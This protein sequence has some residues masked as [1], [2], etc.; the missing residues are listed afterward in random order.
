MAP[1]KQT[2]PAAQGFE[3]KPVV[4]GASSKGAKKTATP[5]KGK[6]VATKG[7]NSALFEKRPRNFGIGQDLP[8]R[9]D[10]TRF[11]RWPK[12][13]RLQRQRQILYQRLKVPPAISQFTYTL[14]KNT[15]AKALKLAEKYA[16]EDKIAKQARLKA[17]AAAKVAGTPVEIKKK[18]VVKFG[19]N[20]I[21]QLVESKKASLVII[22]HDVDPIEVVVWL[23][24]LCRKHGV[25]YAI[26]KG[27][28]R[29]GQ[30]VH[31]KTATAIAF[32][33]V[34][35]EDKHELSTLVQ[36]VQENFNDRLTDRL[37][38]WGGQRLGIKSQTRINRHQKAVA[39]EAEARALASA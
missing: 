3:I 31:K 9:R 12:Y 30:V 32:T 5:A 29:L 13:V 16:P 22:A 28:S 25:P 19:I 17:A 27:K 23:P 1:K 20:H 2:K 35:N 38:H 15:A 26:V 36:A 6:A 39:A 11:V 8:P 21:T 18:N 4:A 34:N 10:L 33:Q 7:K 14:D 37:R 24:S